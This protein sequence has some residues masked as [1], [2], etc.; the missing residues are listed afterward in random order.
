MNKVGL[1]KFSGP[2]LDRIIQDGFVAFGMEEKL[3]RIKTVFLKPNLVVDIK[4]YIDEGANTDIRIIEAILKYLSAYTHLKIYLG[5]SESGTRIKGRKLDRALEI[6]GVNAL[7][8]KYNF[9][10][11]NLT[12]DRHIRV[13]IPGGKFVTDLIMGETLM[14]SDLII[15]LPKIKTH[16]YA[17]I[18]CALK[19][20]FGTIP[21]PRRIIYHKNIHQTLADL[22][23][24]FYDKMFI[25]TDGIVAMEG[26]GPLYGRRVN[27]DVMLFADNPLLNDAT[28]A[29]IMGFDPVKIQHIS[30]CNDWAKCDLNNI[31]IVGTGNLKDVRRNF[32]PSK[33]N[34]FITIEGHLMQHKWIVNILFSEW[35]QTKITYRLR[36]ILKRLRGGSYSWYFKESNKPNDPKR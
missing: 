2:D 21:D 10:I 25:V 22:N 36:H 23:Q 3:R 24:L 28:V 14:A 33:K 30:L 15:N 16:K 26:N 34:L 35:F 19:N 29:Q 32:Q 17:T 11:V 18:T 9:T 12:Y 27:L 31:S 1:Y 8:D 6:M 7:K 13:P 4:Q 5:E 20:M